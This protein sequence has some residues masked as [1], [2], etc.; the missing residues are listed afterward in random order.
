[1]GPKNY[2]FATQELDP[3][4]TVVE[5]KSVA[6][7]RGFSLKHPLNQEKLTPDYFSKL[8]GELMESMATNK[9]R[10]PVYLHQ[11]FFKI[12]ANHNISTINALKNYTKNTFDR[13]VFNISLKRCIENFETLVI[14]IKFLS[15]KIYSLKYFLFI[16]IW[17]L[18]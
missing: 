9:N 14:I 12:D 17:I 7:M 10:K 1:M 16:A 2:F 13:R 4:G 11:Q 3:D 6:K 18:Y 8:L 5:T 15:I